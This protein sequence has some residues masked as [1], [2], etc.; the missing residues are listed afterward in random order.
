MAKGYIGANT[1]KCFLGNVKMK[2]GYIGGTRVYSAGEIVTYV[3]D[4]NNT[5]QEEVDEGESVLSPRTFTPA[6]SGWTFIGWRTNK[7]ANG[8]VLGSLN[9][10]DDPITLYA[11]FRQTI[12][13]SYSGNGNTGGST[14]SQTGY[15]YYNNG[16]ISNPA[17]VLRT[18]GFSK[19]SYVFVNWKSGSTTYTPGQSITIS[20]NI[21]MAA[22]WVAEK[23]EITGSSEYVTFSNG[24]SIGDAFV[25]CGAYSGNGYKCEDDGWVQ[26]TIPAPYKKA[27]VT[28]RF[29][30]YGYGGTTSAYVD[31]LGARKYCDNDVNGGADGI[32]GTWTMTAGG[33]I[34]GHTYY[35]GGTYNNNSWIYVDKVEFTM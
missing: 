10:G 30:D 17:F 12:T 29:R 4:T 8:S 18:N 27:L 13:I 9:M 19:T 26:I 15:R 6:K 14:A 25:G 2:K 33:R 21:S 24:N 5:K 3:I 1:Y 11:V 20:S 7:T 31:G 28:L 35:S 16:S 34:S 23:L 22:Q 32:T